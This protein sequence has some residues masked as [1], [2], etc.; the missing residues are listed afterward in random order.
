MEPE[1]RLER[2]KPFRI[3]LD[4]ERRHPFFIMLRLL[5]LIW[6]LCSSEVDSELAQRCRRQVLADTGQLP[7]S[8]AYHSR[9]DPA[10]WQERGVQRPSSALHLQ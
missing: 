1:L 4:I 2:L 6:R 8:H 3:N 10:P 9:R 7:P 5:D